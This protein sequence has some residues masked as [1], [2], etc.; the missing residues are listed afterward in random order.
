MARTAGMC[1]L[2]P[3]G[4]AA[5]PPSA[6]E[7]CRLMRRVA[8]DQDRAAFATLFGYFAPRLKTFL[9]RS[10]MAERAAEEMVQ[11][12]MLI[13]WRKSSHFDARRA[14]VSTWILTIARNQRIDRLRR[15]RLDPVDTNFDPDAEAE[16]PDSAEQF[17][18]AAQRE[19]QVRSALAALPDEQALIVRLSFFAEK[20]HAE[21][22][23]QLGIP[24]G[25]VKSRMRLA[26]SRLRAL[27][28]GEA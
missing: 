28:Q 21:I 22:A 1:M 6:D 13:V 23:R 12:T 27:L 17:T 20:P 9:L 7:L 15:E 19:A 2:K 18:M 14:G 3:A 10:G 25:T 4:Q 8:V 24:L 26:M 16:W 5:D 11:E